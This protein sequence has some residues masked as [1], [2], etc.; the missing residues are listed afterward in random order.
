MKFSAHLF[1]SYILS[2]S[3][4]K[5]DTSRYDPISV[6]DHQDSDLSLPLHSSELALGFDAL[7]IQLGSL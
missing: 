2:R 7:S 4:E 6:S 5:M 3:S 1:N